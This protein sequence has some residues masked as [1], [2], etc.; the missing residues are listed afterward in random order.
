MF[1]INKGSTSKPTARSDAARFTS[2]IFAAEWNEEVFQ[3]DIR[4]AEFPNSAVRM[5]IARI[6]PTAIR[7]KF[8]SCSKYPL[9]PEEL[10][11]NEEK[12][13]PIATKVF[14]LSKL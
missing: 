5:R 10:F 4:M 7:P 2:K 8:N 3:I 11:E 9:N 13:T 6:I 1:V 12:S 14:C